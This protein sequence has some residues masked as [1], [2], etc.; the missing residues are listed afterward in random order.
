ME[1]RVENAK[2][3]RCIQVPTEL[4]QIALR[5]DVQEQKGKERETEYIYA[6]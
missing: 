1:K 2:E 3:N 5:S 6:N 4:H